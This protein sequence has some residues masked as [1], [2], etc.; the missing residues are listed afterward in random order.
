MLK[1]SGIESGKVY[2]YRE[3]DYMV[4]LPDKPRSLYGKKLTAKCTVGNHRTYLAKGPA[5]METDEKT[6]IGKMNESGLWIDGRLEI[7]IDSSSS[8]EYRKYKNGRKI[9]GS[10]LFYYDFHWHSSP[11]HDKTQFHFFGGNPS[12]DQQNR[13]ITPRLKQSSKNYLNDPAQNLFFSTNKQRD[14]EASH[15]PARNLFFS[16]NK[17]RDLADSHRRGEPLAS[18]AHQDTPL[19]VRV[20]RQGFQRSHS[21][22]IKVEQ[23]GNGPRTGASS[24]TFTVRNNLSRQH[25]LQAGF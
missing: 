12:D 25:S 14:L 18:S 6:Y 19:A 13:K 1:K 21:I 17:Q 16:T 9:Q 20:E 22:P 23:P 5:R 11:R 3:C 7:D 10:T 15:D 2:G 24:S 4:L 8:I